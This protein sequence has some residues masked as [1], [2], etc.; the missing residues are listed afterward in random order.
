MSAS[1]FLR[2]AITAILVV[3]LTFGTYALIEPTDVR[4]AVFAAFGKKEATPQEALEQVSAP[5]AP[6]EML[7]APIA[8]PKKMVAAVGEKQSTSAMTAHAGQTGFLTS[9]VT[10]VR[11]VVASLLSPFVAR[12]QE[13]PG[14]VAV[15]LTPYPTERTVINNTTYNTYNTNT[16]NTTNNR[17]GDTFVT[18]QTSPGAPPATFAPAGPTVTTKKYIYDPDLS[19]LPYLAISGGTLVG[20]LHVNANGTSTFSGGVSVNTLAVLST[21]ATSTFANGINLSDGCFAIDGTCVASAGGVA[22]GGPG[23]QIQFKNARVLAGA[24][25]LSYDD[26]TDVFSFGS[27]S[28]T[29]A[30]TTSFFTQTSSST[31]TFS[32]TATFGNAT[33]GL[34]SEEHTSELQSRLHLVCRLPL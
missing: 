12:K 20:L 11:G 22:A 2:R 25:T 17:G 30:T 6:R 19:G 33:V 15:S 28:G 4:E 10:R 13:D 27:A 26:S 29:A 21:D 23:G 3:T 24:S 8:A 31:Q 7:A 9:V 16:Y 14:K 18:N 32:N 34:R 1:L 5:A